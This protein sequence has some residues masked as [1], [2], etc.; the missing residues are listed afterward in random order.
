M[1]YELN[2]GFH[3]S[4]ETEAATLW[5]GLSERY[6]DRQMQMQADSWVQGQPGMEEI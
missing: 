2:K 1:Q 4:T 6:K 3:G 5:A